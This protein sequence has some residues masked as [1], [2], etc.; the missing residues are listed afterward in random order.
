[1]WWL[2][3]SEYSSPVFSWVT[4]FCEDRHWHSIL[5]TLLFTII[6]ADGARPMKRVKHLSYDYPPVQWN[7]FEFLG[8][9]DSE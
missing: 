2:S 3:L 5:V 4:L 8:N 6:Y 1:M 7:P 9:M